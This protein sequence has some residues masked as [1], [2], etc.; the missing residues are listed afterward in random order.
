MVKRVSILAIAAAALLAAPADV[1]AKRTAKDK[2]LYEK[3]L[4]ECNGPAYPGG[5]HILINYADG[6]YRCETRDSRR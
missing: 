3:A 4:K 5:A 6:W 1:Q 2:A